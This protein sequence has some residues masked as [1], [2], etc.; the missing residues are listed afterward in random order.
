[1]G[2]AL[3]TCAGSYFVQ[4]ASNSGAVNY[5]L[6]RG[7]ESTPRGWCSPYYYDREAALSLAL[8]CQASSVLL[9]TTFG[10]SPSTVEAG[11]T[12]LTIKNDRWQGLIQLAQPVEGSLLASV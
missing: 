10:A 11:A 5:S 2:L 3:S 1:G 9:W 7:E 6:V 4:L 8:T 12:H